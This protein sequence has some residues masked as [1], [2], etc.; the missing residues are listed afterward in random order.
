MI[1]L[2]RTGFITK[3]LLVLPD[4]RQGEYIA[5]A[6]QGQI[7]G[8]LKLEK[9]A[10]RL[11]E[12][13]QWAGLWADCAFFISE[14]P[15]CKRMKAKE[16]TSNT[17]LKPLPQCTFLFQTVS[18]DLKGSYKVKLLSFRK[19]LIKKQKQKQKQLLN[20]FM[21]ILFVNFQLQ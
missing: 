21:K 19:Y 12:H 5:S 15:I 18:L 16:K 7:G 4:T 17:Y 2:K 1:R 20:A 6:H 9:T 10:N 13:V 14:C 11:L 8:H 3:D